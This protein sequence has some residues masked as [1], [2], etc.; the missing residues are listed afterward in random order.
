VYID[1]ATFEKR[2]L[3]LDDS[4]FEVPGHTST[5]LAYVMSVYSF[6]LSPE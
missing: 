1:D 4:D 6:Y 5:N 3:R 2:L